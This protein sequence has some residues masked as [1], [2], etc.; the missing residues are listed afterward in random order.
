MKFTGNSLKRV[1]RAMELALIELRRQRVID[2]D[3]SDTEILE[4]L[5]VKVRVDAA[6]RVEEV[7]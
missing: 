1:Q 3:V 6:V 5:R 7:L 4:M 2:P